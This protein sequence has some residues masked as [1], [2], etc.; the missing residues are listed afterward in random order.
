MHSSEAAC[1]N[2]MRWHG[3]TLYE[4]ATWL[5]MPNVKLAVKSLRKEREREIPT[6][7]A[8]QLV[9]ILST[10][11]DRFNFAVKEGRDSHKLASEWQQ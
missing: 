9:K 5:K 10:E 6:N 7:P 8:L 4:V 2:Y 1:E 3:T 11:F